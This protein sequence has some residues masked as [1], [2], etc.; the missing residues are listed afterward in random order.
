MNDDGAPWDKF[1]GH[2][3]KWERGAEA[4]RDG[5]APLLG[6]EWMAEG[7]D[8]YDYVYT[9]ERRLARARPGPA[10]EAAR[11]ALAYVRSRCVTDIV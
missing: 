8:D 9:L 1:D 5:V 11:Q 7:R 6:F 4:T 10:A 2:H 3:Y